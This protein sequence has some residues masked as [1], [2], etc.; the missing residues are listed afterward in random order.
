MPKAALNDIA[1]I[2]GA[3][4]RYLATHPEASETLEGVTRW[5]LTR[6]RYTDSLAS[7]QSALDLLERKGEVDKLCLSGGTVL[8]RKA[9]LQQSET[10]REP[11]G[12]RPAANR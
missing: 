5:W 3:I 7:V 9:S 10:N 6:Q 12:T 8:Y 2:A 4:N 1:G 11:M